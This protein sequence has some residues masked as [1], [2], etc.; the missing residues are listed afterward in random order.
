MESRDSIYGIE[1]YVY[2]IDMT[3]LI[4]PDSHRGD[5]LLSK[6]GIIL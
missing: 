6:T 5:L 2:G 1:V 3:E 4:L